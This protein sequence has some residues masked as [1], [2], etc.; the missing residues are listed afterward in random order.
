MYK[1]M[2]HLAEKLSEYER[3][4]EQGLLIKLPCELGKLICRITFN[5]HDGYCIAVDHFDV[6]MIE[7]FGKTVFLSV[8]E[9]EKACLE[10]QSGFRKVT[11]NDW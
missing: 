3:A 2:R 9:A 6:S 5:Q 10:K 8:G 11:R 1:I 4:E 7:E